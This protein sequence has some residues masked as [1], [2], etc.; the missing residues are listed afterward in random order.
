MKLLMNR[1]IVYYKVLTKDPKL[2]DTINL[3][4]NGILKVKTISGI[5]VYL[6][7]KLQETLMGEIIKTFEKN[8]SCQ[9]KCEIYY[10]SPLL[11]RPL[12]ED[13]Y[14]KKPNEINLGK[15]EEIILSAN[16]PIEFPKDK[17]IIDM[18]EFNKNYELKINL[19]SAECIIRVG[20]YKETTIE[21]I[22][23]S[24]RWMFNIDTMN[25]ISL[26]Y[27]KQKLNDSKYIKDY[28]IQNNETLTLYINTMEFLESMNEHKEKLKAYPNY[29]IF[30]KTL[31]GTTLEFNVTEK[32][33]VE[34]LKHLI[35]QKEMM[36][37]NEIRLIFAGKQLEDGLTLT[38]YGIKIESTLHMVLRLRGGMY[39]ET[40]GKA[41]NYMPLK[42]CIILVD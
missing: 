37:Y 29:R 20:V 7:Y 30:V 4:T 22:K 19:E 38:K 34:N 14:K 33:T 10:N 13:D 25:Q 12:N 36:G 26:Y 31:T 35:V 40:S 18:T 17:E 39:H 6:V 1:L 27:H 15:N 32:H 42:S 41:G 8:Y 5:I 11:K 28:N 16:R 24:I 3:D 2:I 23:K 21:A 9:H